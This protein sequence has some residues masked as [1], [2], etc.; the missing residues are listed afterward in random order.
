RHRP[1]PRGSQAAAATRPPRRRAALSSPV[2]R[3]NSYLGLYG[4]PGALRHGREA[5]HL[6]APLERLHGE[7][8][9]LFER[10]PE[11]L[12]AVLVP[13]RREHPVRRR[14]ALDEGALDRLAVATVPLGHLAQEAG[15]KGDVAVL[16]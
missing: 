6:E 9:R 15:A 2:S 4:Y 14:T 5:D 8:A 3:A 13:R 12:H 10:D 11:E 1:R 16:V 7:L